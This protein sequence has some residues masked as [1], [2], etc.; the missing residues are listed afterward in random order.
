MIPVPVLV[1]PVLVI[2]VLVIPVLVLEIPALVRAPVI[3]VLVSAPAHPT[4]RSDHRHHR[5][6]SRS[7]KQMPSLSNLARE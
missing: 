2:P 6:R 1:I 5:K 7:C 3:R 4:R